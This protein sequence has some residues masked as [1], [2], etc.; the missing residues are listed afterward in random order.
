MAN[1]KETA[2]ERAARYL[3]M[4][5]AQLDSEYDTLR[6]GDIALAEVAGMEMHKA[7][8]NKENDLSIQ[9]PTLTSTLT[10]N[11]AGKVTEPSD[12]TIASTPKAATM[13][14]EF[15]P[16]TARYYG[17]SYATGYG[18]AKGAKGDEN[19][20]AQ[21]GRSA[22]QILKFLDELPEGTVTGEDIVI[23]SGVVNSG[24]DLDIVAQQIDLLLMGG[25]RSIR[26]L[27]T[28]YPDW[29]D[30]LRALAKRKGVLFRSLGKI[31][32]D[33]IHPGHYDP[34]SLR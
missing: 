22:D 18:P 8:Y 13:T 31:G 29:D 7:Y 20:N 6:A 25:A 30:H 34:N 4:N 27:G 33:N 12:I 5:K 19:S 21:W 23:S 10:S 28:P 15:D 16:S 2:K 17:D 9:E 11:P 14:R 32:P 1:L 24:L 26:V 3:T